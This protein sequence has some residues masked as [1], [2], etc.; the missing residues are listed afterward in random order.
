[1]STCHVVLSPCCVGLTCRVA[2]STCHVIFWEYPKP[3][4]DRTLDSELWTLDSGPPPPPP[5]PKK[6][7]LKKTPKSPSLPPSKILYKKE[8][9]KRITSYGDIDKSKKHFTP[10]SPHHKINNPPKF[11]VKKKET[12]HYVF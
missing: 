5:P 10:P 3:G 12:R 2:L 1:M 11:L 4:L 8:R 6:I 9:E 7:T